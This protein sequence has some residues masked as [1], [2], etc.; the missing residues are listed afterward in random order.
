MM[1]RLHLGLS[2]QGRPTVV[3]DGST[4]LGYLTLSRSWENWY[5]RTL[6]GRNL[7]I[8]DTFLPNWFDSTHH[9]YSTEVKKVPRKGRALF[10]TEDIPKDHFVSPNDAAMSI[11]IDRVQWDALNKFISDFPE[12][13]QFQQLRDFFFAYGFESEAL[14]VGGWAVSIACNNTFVNHGCTEEER[15]ITPIEYVFNGEDGDEVQ[16]SP[17]INRRED[18]LGSLVMTSR[19]VKAGEE[20]AMD[21]HYLRNNYNEE[22]DVFLKHVCSDG[23]GLV[24]DS[25][26]DA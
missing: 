19:D 18:L 16:F 26:D 5:C 12:A 8:C 22:F 17:P 6:P 1:N 3:Y 20:I 24:H 13:N 25:V 7:P 11:R 23:T 21:Y 9:S 4:H 15:T 2:K 10:A 14:G